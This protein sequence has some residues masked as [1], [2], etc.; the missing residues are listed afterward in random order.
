MTRQKVT[1]AKLRQ[2]ITI[3]NSLKLGQLLQNHRFKAGFAIGLAVLGLV[4]TVA[5]ILALGGV[6]QQETTTLL[7]IVIL[8][9]IV[10]VITIV[11]LIVRR[12][13]TM[14]SARRRKSAGSR[15]H[16]RL[17][18]VF[19]LI[20]LIPTV[21]IA[22]F[23]TVTVNFGLEELFSDRVQKVVGASVDAATAYETE[24]REN[25]ISDARLLGNFLNAQKQRFPMI[26]PAEFR[27][28][29]SS[30][31]KQI[32]RGLDEAYVIDGA[33]QI[34][35]RG[36]RSYLFDFEAPRQSQIAQARNGEVVV[37]EDWDINEFRALVV[38]PAFADRFLYITRD[39]NGD[40]LNLLDQTQE[41]ATR[42]REVESER[43]RLLLEFGLLYVGIALIVILAAVWIG[44]WFAERL[45]RPVGRLAG[46]AQRVGAGD[47]NVRVREEAGDDEIAMLGR[48]FNRMTQ[49]VKAQRD[50]LMD[51]NVETEKSS[52]LFN[53]I[54]TGVSSGVIGLDARGRVEM[55]NTAATKLLGVTHEDAT[56]AQLAD[57]APE[58]V[59]LLDQLKGKRDDAVVQ[60]VQVSRGG[61]VENLLVRVA[62][63]SSAGQLEGYVVA[64]DDVTALVSAQRMAAWG[65]VARRI[66]HEIK[67]PLTPI[68][69][70]AERMR[71]KFGPA[72]GDQQEAL[73]Q[74]ADVIIRQ[75]EDLRR[76]VDEFSKFAR[77]PAPQRI[78]GDIL[79]SIKDATLLFQNG[80][81]DIDV[82][83]KIPKSPINIE[84]DGTM[85]GQVL[86]NLLKNAGE[87]IDTRL[88]NHPD[89]SGDPEIRV[90]AK[91]DHDALQISIQDNG[92]GLPDQRVRLLEPYVTQRDSGTGLGLSIVNKIVEE[93]SGQLD[94]LDAPRF[95]GS[96]K[97][98]A[99]IRITLPGVRS[100]K[101]RS[102][103]ATQAVA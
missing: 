28:L 54:L 45:S 40:I 97:Q 59:K 38:L 50:A 61:I 13:A 43:S 14:I 75:T 57:I 100:A 71:R 17:T 4:L 84:F 21:A 39:V 65:D 89:W 41:T 1:E 46:A 56:D 16:M 82:K 78:E 98:G 96:S 76:I 51:I 32:Q 64:F 10:F 20:A 88:A 30:G 36:E 55:I 83:V 8:A 29:L 18:G 101:D 35:A 92:I 24:H 95:K 63:R 62:S 6:D 26:S 58:F 73:E 2:S 66:A 91:V 74:Y 79:T 15:L 69:L 27:S 11:A 52:R 3:Q 49:Q 60:D 67:N 9:D 86:N 33:A 12:L 77:M 5:T 90:I 94:L 102:D 23:S 34:K 87:A 42:F 31:Q 19:T 44:L 7:R 103:S 25:I 53:S 81:Q 80:R 72:L 99:E 85:I 47:F 93:H 68:Q 48:A 37:I 22:I 70:S